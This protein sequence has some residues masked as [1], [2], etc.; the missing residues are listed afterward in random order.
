MLYRKANY[1][2]RAFG[3]NAEITQNWVDRWKKYWV[4][5]YIKA[6]ECGGVNESTIEQWHNQKLSKGN[7]NYS[8][9]TFFL[10]AQFL[11]TKNS[12]L[13]YARSHQFLSFVT[14]TCC[15]KLT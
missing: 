6:S 8:K 13:G 2:A 9:K 11:Q 5:Y 12:I 3:K 4:I 7:G 1:F 10:D 14:R 15:P